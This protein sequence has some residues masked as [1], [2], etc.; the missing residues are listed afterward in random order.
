MLFRY[1]LT[2]LHTNHRRFVMSLDRAQLMGEPHTLDELMARSDTNFRYNPPYANSAGIPYYPCGEI[3]NSMFNDTFH[4][5][6][7]AADGHVYPV[8]SRGIAWPHDRPTAAILARGLPVGLQQQQHAE[9][10]GLGG[11]SCV[12]AARGPVTL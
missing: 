2:N 7:R 3:A 12:D 5:P 10:A 8:T 1:K 4:A 11:V 9:P 6:V